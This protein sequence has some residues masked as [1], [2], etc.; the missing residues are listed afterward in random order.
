MRR[1]PDL[2]N[3]NTADQASPKGKDNW[4]NDYPNGFVLLVIMAMLLFVIGLVTKNYL[5]VQ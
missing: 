2:I 4:V 1:L 3:K 5:A